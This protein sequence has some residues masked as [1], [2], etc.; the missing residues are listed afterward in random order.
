MSTERR[1]SSPT[2]AVEVALETYAAAMLGDPDDYRDTQSWET[3]RDAMHHALAAALEHAIKHLDDA[4]R[5]LRSGARDAAHKGDPIR[6]NHWHSEAG[7]VE[8]AA[9][10]LRS[11][12]PD[13]TPD[14]PTGGE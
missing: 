7:G 13:S 8:Y 4:S 11:L 12:L 10:Y 14:Q 6:M 2:D 3:A 5:E 1:N 9:N